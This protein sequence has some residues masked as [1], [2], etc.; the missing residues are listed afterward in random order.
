MREKKDNRNEQIRMGE[1]R[2]GEREIR[3]KRGE[4]WRDEIGEISVENQREEIKCIRQTEVPAMSDVDVSQ[5]AKIHRLKVDVQ[6]TC[7]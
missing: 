3:D 6:C 1:A 2:R 5:L 7:T 4:M